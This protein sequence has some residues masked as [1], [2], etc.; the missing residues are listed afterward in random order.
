MRRSARPVGIRAVLLVVWVA[1][2]MSNTDGADI[3]RLST[4]PPS[5]DFGNVPPRAQLS[6]TLTFNNVGKASLVIRDIQ[7]SCSCVQPSV[8]TVTIDA[9]SHGGVEVGL[10]TPDLSGPFRETLSFV[11]TL[12]F[13]I[14]RRP[15]PRC[16]N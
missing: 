7:A 1:A 15:P 16:L 8:R 5:L 2:L 6:S 3:P 13:S 9:G 10:L 12:A 14:C 4:I 11:S